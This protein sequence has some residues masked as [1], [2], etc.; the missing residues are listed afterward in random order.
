MEEQHRILEQ[1]AEWLDSGR[2]RTTLT[3]KLSPIS[4]ANLRAAHARV[5]SGKMVGKL[6]LAGW[7]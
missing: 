5:E 2:L 4:A 1:V 3:E 7:R 6:V